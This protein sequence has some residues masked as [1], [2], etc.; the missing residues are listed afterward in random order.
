LE[1]IARFFDDLDAAMDDLG[2]QVNAGAYQL[3]QQ[4]RKEML[5]G[6]HRD[7]NEQSRTDPTPPEE[8]ESRKNIASPHRR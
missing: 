2:Q 1:A 8:S 7:L 3:S 5:Q 6:V 4:V